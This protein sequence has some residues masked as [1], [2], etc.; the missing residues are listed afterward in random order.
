MAIKMDVFGYSK[1]QIAYKSFLKLF[2]D[3]MN[4]LHFCFDDSV[5]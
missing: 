1:T 3:L 2:F 5:D 4:K